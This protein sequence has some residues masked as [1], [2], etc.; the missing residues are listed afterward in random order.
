MLRQ[1]DSDFPFYVC[2][3]LSSDKTNP[4]HTLTYDVNYLLKIYSI[5]PYVTDDNF[6]TFIAIKNEIYVLSI[7][8]LFVFRVFVYSVSST[9]M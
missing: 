3:R 5:C 4:G 6:T 7:F 1:V 9:Y 8:T 2:R